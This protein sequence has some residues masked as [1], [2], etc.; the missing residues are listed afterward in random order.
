M[1]ILL[2]DLEQPALILLGKTGVTYQNQTAGMKCDQR[3]AEGALLPVPSYFVADIEGQLVDA[4]G[5][6]EEQ[7]AAIETA[8]R[9]ADRNIRLTVNRDMLNDSQEAWLHVIVNSSEH[10]GP[11]VLTWENSD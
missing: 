8:W 3:T 7:A 11:A 10:N 5:I 6:S 1:H 4:D 2:Y 9:S